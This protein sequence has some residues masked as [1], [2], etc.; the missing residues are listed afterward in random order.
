MRRV[1]TT[2]A[3]SRHDVLGR[4]HPLSQEAAV[5]LVSAAAAAGAELS[6]RIPPHRDPIP[7]ERG[8]PGG[9]EEPSSGEERPDRNPPSP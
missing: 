4:E 1:E 2:G 3:S 7:A 6:A 9:A 5:A 8:T